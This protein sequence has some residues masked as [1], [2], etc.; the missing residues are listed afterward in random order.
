MK[1]SQVPQVVNLCSILGYLNLFSVHNFLFHYKT[2]FCNTN[3]FITYLYWFAVDNCI[4]RG[5]L[6][7]FEDISAELKCHWP[8]KMSSFLVAA[9]IKKLITL[10]CLHLLTYICQFLDSEFL[11]DK[12]EVPKKS[13]C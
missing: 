12:V 5:Q 6:R 7:Y 13:G 8:V 9:N 2:P 3:C 1:A 10:W 4:L 11:G